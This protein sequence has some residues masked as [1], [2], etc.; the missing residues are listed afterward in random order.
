MLTRLP[1]LSV[2][3]VAQTVHGRPVRFPAGG[4]ESGAP[5]IPI[6]VPRGTEPSELLATRNTMG[7]GRPAASIAEA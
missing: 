7:L 3:D 2:P 1:D 5:G 6:V 4:S